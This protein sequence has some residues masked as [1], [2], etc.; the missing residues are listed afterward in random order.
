M[1]ITRGVMEEMDELRELRL[2]RSAD[3]MVAGLLKSRSEAT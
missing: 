2:M 1:S 3:G